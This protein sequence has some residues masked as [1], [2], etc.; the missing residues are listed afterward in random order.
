MPVTTKL[1]RKQTWTFIEGEWADLI[2]VA[3]AFR[4]GKTA[5]AIM[6]L[7]AKMLEHPHT[8]LVLRSKYQELDDIIR[9]ELEKWLPAEELARP[10]KKQ[11]PYDAHLKNGG[12]IMF[13]HLE[14]GMTDLR[15]VSAGSG[16]R[17]T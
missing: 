17:Y 5:A 9:P 16:R 1:T 15:G 11:Y 10:L 4:G 7:V 2:V 3:G 12:R 6:W 13:R 14:K 8:A